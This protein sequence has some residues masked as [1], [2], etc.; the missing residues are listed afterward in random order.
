MALRTAITPSV[1]PPAAIAKSSAD[2]VVQRAHD[3]LPSCIR[4]RHPA[5]MHTDI[6]IRVARAAARSI[7][8]AWHAMHVTYVTTGSIG[9]QVASN[10]IADFSKSVLAPKYRTE[11]HRTSK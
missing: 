7:C 1:T 6:Y 10:Q 4:P 8:I 5:I 11:A 9:F 2:V 3:D